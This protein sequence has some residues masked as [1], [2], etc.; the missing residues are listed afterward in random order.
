MK[1]A[2]IVTR[3]DDLG[4]AQVHVRD[5]AEAALLQGHDVTVLTGGTGSFTAELD[6]R[7]IA[8]RPIPNLVQPI[9]PR[10]D[11]K[12]LFE[13]I[14]ALRAI[15]PDIVATHT[16]KAGLL[17]RLAARALARPAV[18]TPHG[19]SIA[20]RISRPKGFVFRRIEA[21][22]SLASSRIINVCNF[23]VELALKYG[24]A[25]RRKLAMVHNGLADIP[26]ERP[27]AVTAG[28]PA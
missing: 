16:A 5:L 21:L 22:A 9:A 7:G 13:I 27:A 8:H 26:E 23:E 20:D 11:V 6:A 1:I 4:G 18:F 17:G 15:Q 25:P 19:W 24:I 12:A 28:P 14:A 3:G 2:Y 10:K